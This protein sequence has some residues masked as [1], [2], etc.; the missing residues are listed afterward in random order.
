[1]TELYSHVLM[2]QACRSGPSRS[3]PGWPRNPLNPRNHHSNTPGE[4]GGAKQKGGEGV[5][6]FRGFR[7]HPILIEVPEGIGDAMEE[8][9]D[10]PIFQRLPI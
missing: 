1:M 9:P 3:T 10:E 6:G 2:A 4:D 8:M 7:G 5:R